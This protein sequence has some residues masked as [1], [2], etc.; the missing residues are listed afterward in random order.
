MQKGKIAAQCSHAT[1][2]VYKQVARKQPGLAAA[3]EA[4]AQAKIVL[5]VQKHRQTVV[6][7]INSP[8]T[9]N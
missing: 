8:H 1:L 9:P 4:A 3:W 5:K 6:P 7:S 2:G